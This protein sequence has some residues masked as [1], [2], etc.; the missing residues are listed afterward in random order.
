MPNTNPQAL[1]VMNNKIRVAADRFGQAYNLFKAM[2][3]EAQAEGWMA[4]FPAD[5]EIVEDGSLTDGRTRITNQ[6]TRDFITDVGSFIT[7]CEASSNAVRN[8]ALKI[9][10]NPEKI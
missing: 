3:A 1:S 4:L 5:S 8:R 10:V 2:Q 9:A 7:F 6:E